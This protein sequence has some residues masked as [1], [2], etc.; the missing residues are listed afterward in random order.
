MIPKI[1][2]AA[3]KVKVKVKATAWTF[4][5]KAWGEGQDK[6][7]TNLISM[8]LKAKTWPRELH[9][10]G[11]C[12]V[13]WIVKFRNKINKQGV[14]RAGL[15]ADVSIQHASRELHRQV[16]DRRGVGVN[17]E[18]ETTQHSRPADLR[19]LRSVRYIQVSLTTHLLMF[20]LPPPV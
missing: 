3:L 10:C 14:G 18:V 19:R 1:V 7:Y 15:A 16:Q 8:R 20:L 13:A 12:S 6:A 9:H 2:I 5:A 17:Q 4:E 11:C